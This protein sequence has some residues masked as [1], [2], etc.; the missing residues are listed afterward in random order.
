MCVCDR[1]QREGNN[2]IPASK[3]WLVNLN[4][5]TCQLDRVRNV[6]AVRLLVV[7][8]KVMSVLLLHWKDWLY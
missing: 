8:R 1:R 6:W 3:V 2:M 5:C 4:A 7:L